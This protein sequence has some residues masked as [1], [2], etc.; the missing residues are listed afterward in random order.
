M[1]VLR[2]TAALLFAG[3]LVACS[4]AG[5]TPDFDV[6]K[7]L[8]DSFRSRIRVAPEIEVLPSEQIR[9]IVFPPKS[10]KPV[11]FIDLRLGEVKG[12]N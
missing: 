8:K 5:R 11:K 9:Q 4:P 6:V 1:N 3:L 7:T 2:S 12:K 10:R